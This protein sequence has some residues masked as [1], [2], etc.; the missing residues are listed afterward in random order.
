[1]N[2][3]GKFFARQNLLPEILAV[4]SRYGVNPS[5]LRLE[6]TEDDLIANPESAAQVLAR[7]SQ[8]GI[9]I[10]ID[11]FGTGYSSLGYLSSLPVRGLKIDQSF[12]AGLHSGEKSATIVRSI[13][14]LGQNLGLDVIAEG[15]ETE[16]QLDYLREVGC[17]YVQGFYFSRAV[18]QEAAIR[19]FHE[20]IPVA[21]AKTATPTFC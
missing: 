5:H 8:A 1:M 9:Q 17:P 2:L 3:P 12:V 19:L 18:E 14:S 16:G 21:C 11:D 20:G 15:V 4:V 7:L 6:I 13:V 10:L